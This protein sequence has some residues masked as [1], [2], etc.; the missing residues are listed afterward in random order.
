MRYTGLKLA[1]LACL[2]GGLAAAQSMNNIST[3][4]A[5]DPPEDEMP[6]RMRPFVDTDL[7]EARNY[8]EQ[9]P[10]IPHDVEGYEVSRNYNKCLSCHARAATGRSQ[11]PMVSVTHYIDRHG[12]VLASVSPRRYFC[13]QCHVPQRPDEPM[14]TNTFIDIDTLLT[15]PRE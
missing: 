1:V 10:L 2:V 5:T 12:Q 14:V 13:N 6:P 9:P 4:R 7:R 8:P 11:A 3:L 15:M